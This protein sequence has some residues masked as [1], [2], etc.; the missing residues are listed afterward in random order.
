MQRE[1]AADFPDGDCDVGVQDGA[2]LR[3][4]QH[5]RMTRLCFLHLRERA[6]W[7]ERAILHLNPLGGDFVERVPVE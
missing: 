3:F 1:R 6:R 7:V 5:L 2:V 4:C